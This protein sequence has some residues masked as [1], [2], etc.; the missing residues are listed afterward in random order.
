[1][2]SD[3]LKADSTLMGIESFAY[4]LILGVPLRADPSF[5]YTVD[6]QVYSCLI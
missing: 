2:Y 3:L 5:Y 6:D 1:M 4:L